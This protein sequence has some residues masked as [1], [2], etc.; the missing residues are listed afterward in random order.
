[1]SSGWIGWVCPIC[2]RVHKPAIRECECG[3]CSIIGP[4]KSENEEIKED[5]QDR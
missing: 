1:M 2:G 5:D 3:T 4:I